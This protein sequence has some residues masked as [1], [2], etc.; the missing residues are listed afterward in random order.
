MVST[1]PQHLYIY[2]RDGTFFHLHH[3]RFPTFGGLTHVVIGDSETK[4]S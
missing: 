2:G 3:S 4:D 1:V